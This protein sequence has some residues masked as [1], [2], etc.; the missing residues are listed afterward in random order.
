MPVW[1][2]DHRLLFPD[3][4]MADP[5]GLLAIG[6]D[7]S[8]ERLHLAYTSG[9][10]P[11]FILDREPFWFSPDPRCVLP[12]NEIRISTSMRRLLQKHAFSVTINHD[13]EGVITGCAR[14]PRKHDHT[15]WIDQD[16]IQAYISL[17]EKG[18]AHAVEVWDKDEL[19]G[20][21]YGVAIGACFFG[22]SMFSK[23][24]NA[25][26]YGFIILVEHLQKSGYHFVDCQ[27]YN[28]H[29]ASLGAR[30]ISRETFLQ[31]LAEALNC[32][33]EN[34]LQKMQLDT[35]LI[36]TPEQSTGL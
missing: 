19:V 34:P 12:C 26:K 9:I 24:S 36:V 8:V 6:G 33:P 13:F 10:F 30:D 16:F 22:E 4:S 35:Q 28:N 29:L 5:D 20:G 2:L 27:V 18:I 23:V 3:P 31:M 14:I 32:I 15:T 17:H 25:S 11:W 1:Q 21:L 7:L